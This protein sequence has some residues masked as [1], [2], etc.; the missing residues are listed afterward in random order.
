[1]HAWTQDDEAKEFCA[2][3]GLERFGDYPRFFFYGSGKFHDHDRL[4]GMFRK[5]PTAHESSVLVRVFFCLQNGSVFRQPNL[6]V[7]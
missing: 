1:M 5:P 3:I 4:T 7:L 6:L 2:E